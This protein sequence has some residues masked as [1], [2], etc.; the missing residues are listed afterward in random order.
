MKQHFGAVEGVPV[1]AHFDTRAELRAVGLHRPLVNG[2]SGS[3]EAGAESIVL[4]GGYV[5]DEDHGDR[6]VYTGA[7][8]SCT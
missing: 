2:I 1:G 5:D 8:P 7:A 3:G 4:S 6:L